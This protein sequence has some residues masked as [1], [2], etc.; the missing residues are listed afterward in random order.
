MPLVV[1]QTFTLSS[2]AL[3]SP[4]ARIP[5]DISRIV[6]D[7]LKCFVTDHFFP[8]ICNR[9]YSP[10]D[11]HSSLIFFWVYNPKRGGGLSKPLRLLGKINRGLLLRLHGDLLESNS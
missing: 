4:N 7:V 8:L 10:D 2:E 3:P 5:N 6:M 9:S 11:G 1:I